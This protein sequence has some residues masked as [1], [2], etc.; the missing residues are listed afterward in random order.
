MSD[1]EAARAVA[2]LLGWAQLEAEIRTELS[3]HG[4]DPAPTDAVLERCKKTFETRPDAFFAF[5]VQIDNPT[6]GEGVQRALQEAIRPVIL[7]RVHAWDRLFLQYAIV[8]AEA[9]A[10]R[11]QLE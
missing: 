3:R 11:R 10:L 2:R 7:H 5:D 8:C 6:D 1:F 9:E 4:W